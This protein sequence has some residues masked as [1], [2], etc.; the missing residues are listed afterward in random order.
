MAAC[1][2]AYILTRTWVATDDCGNSNTKVQNITVEDNQ[3]PTIVGI[4]ADLTVECDVV[5][6]IPN[7][8]ITD[9]CDNDITIS[10]NETRADGAC[11]DVYTLTRTWTA[12]DNCGNTETK[13]QTILVEDTTNPILTGIPSD[14]TV[15]CDEIP[16][17]A[18]PNATD[19]CDTNVLITFNESQS[20]SGSNQYILTRSWTA[21]D[22]CNNS[23]IGTQTITVVD[24]IE[25]VFDSFDDETCVGGTVQFSTQ[26]QGSDYSY[27]WSTNFGDFNNDTIFNP[28]LTTDVEGVYSIELTVLHV[29]GCSG[30]ALATVTV[31]QDLVNAAASSNS[32]VCSG[33]DIE[34]FGA[35]GDFYEWSGPNGFSSTQQNPIIPNAD[36]S[37][38]GQY[39]LIISDID[40]CTAEE[41]VDVIVNT[42]IA[43]SFTT[44]NAD[45]DSLGNIEV[46]VSGGSGNYTFNWADINLTSEPQNRDSLLPGSYDLTITDDSGC[47]NIIEKI[48]IIDD[49]ISCDAD[50]GNLTID[51]AIA[52]LNNG[53]ATISATS[54]GNINAPPGFG[55]IYLLSEQPGN[56][57]ITFDNDAD[58]IVNNAGNYTIHTLVYDMSENVVD[59]IS[60]NQTTIFDIE[61]LLIQGGGSI[62]GDLDL[63]GA[64]A[65]SMQVTFSVDSITEDFCNL[66]DGS[67]I[68]SPDTLN[69]SWS[70]GGTGYLR[71]GLAA[72]IYHVTATD[73]NNCSNSIEIEIEGDCDCEMPEIQIQ[74]VDSECD[75]SIGVAHLIPEGNVSDYSFAWST[76]AGDLNTLGN[77]MS[78]LTAGVYTVTV[79]SLI[80]SNCYSVV[81]VAVGNTDGPTPD[82]VTTSTATCDANNGSVVFE[83]VNY[84]Y[85]WLHDGLSAFERYDLSA[86]SYQINVIDPLNPDCENFIE[87]EV[88]QTNP[89]T[90]ELTIL[91]EPDCNESNGKVEIVVLGGSGNYNYAWSDN[92]SFDQPIRN[93]LKEGDYICTITDLDA[94]YCE[95]IV[96]FTL[97]N[98]IIGANV[99]IDPTAAVSCFGQTDGTV[100]FNTTFEPDFDLPVQ[101]II[102]DSLGTFYNNGALPP[103]DYCLTIL[104]ASGCVG[105]IECFSVAEPELLEANFQVFNGFCENNGAIDIS[106]S[107]GS[108]TYSFDWSDINTGTETEDRIDLESGTYD[109]TVTDENGCTVE[110]SNILVEMIITEDCF[111]DDIFVDTVFVNEMDT[112]CVDTSELFGNIVSIENA[113]E[114]A[115]GELVLFELIEDSWCVTYLGI[116]VGTEEACIVIC[117]DLGFCDTTLMIITVIETDDGSGWPKPPI[118]VDDFENINPHETITIEVLENDTINGVLE[119][120]YLV[121][122][123]ANGLAVLN[124]DGTVSY[125]IEEASCE[126]LEPDTFD[127]AICNPVGCDTATVSVSIACDELII[128]TGVSPNDDGVND[129]FYIEGIE[130]YPDNTVSVF[131]RWGNEV[132]Y[133]ESYKNDWKGTYE[134]KA[135]PDGTYFYILEDGAGKSYSGYLQILR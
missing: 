120:I 40:G 12:T 109:L 26:A 16:A 28:V 102:Q 9:N 34:L 74:V 79:T 70:D 3:K 29:S 95:S 131:N 128:Y 36:L 130:N 121:T 110:L 77:E 101:Y 133:K 65:E 134:N 14:A 66:S 132:F 80:V 104:S 71:N 87:V 39:S 117:D 81:T 108:G 22:N 135:L 55:I 43:A 93:D 84:T 58:F 20:G 114:D 91:M 54:L 94:P 49:C 1:E 63:G 50:A 56:T 37:L 53:E 23:V 78:G 86:G 129:V 118:A 57:I 127:Y 97:Q 88:G 116:E 99:I 25:V 10:F 5:P 122:F 113:C 38:M 89:L 47:E 90:A 83:P 13:I 24:S 125:S 52:C 67:V 85:I 31:S 126:K 72:G 100:Y 69:Y 119:D 82:Y 8:T 17:I 75:T 96:A 68:L 7:P 64:S 62:C 76:T 59:S 11:F 32:P 106:V 35:G 46:N 105:A 115:S 73:S 21:T 98:V 18:N 51:N 107:G 61:A 60:M 45:C 6:G 124:N 112:F 27:S 2:D 92:V 48:I 15:H 123:P 4:P 33:N 103:G 41:S 111:T 19:N 42:E 30:T 44:Q